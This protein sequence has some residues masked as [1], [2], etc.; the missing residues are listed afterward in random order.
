[1]L[2]AAPTA[3]NWRASRLL[4]K[5]EEV[6]QM[7]APARGLLDP[8]TFSGTDRFP[9]TIRRRD[10]LP[11]SKNASGVYLDTAGAYGIAPTRPAK[12]LGS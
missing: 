4:Q 6:G 8:V 1:M 12:P 7:I 5:W 11:K 9:G 10:L 3:K 2:G